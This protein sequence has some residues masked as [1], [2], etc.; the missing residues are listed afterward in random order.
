MAVQ[1][2]A[3]ESE[4]RVNE[5]SSNGVRTYVGVVSL[6]LVPFGPDTIYVI[7]TAAADT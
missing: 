5:I 1:T 6:A 2:K 3:R 7:I 4:A